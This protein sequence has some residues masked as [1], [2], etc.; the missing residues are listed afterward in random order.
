ME[1]HVLLELQLP[2]TIKLFLNPYFQPSLTLSS[3]LSNSII[4]VSERPGQSPKV[5]DFST[6]LSKTFRLNTQNWA[7][8]LSPENQ[9]LLLQ[10]SV[11]LKHLLTHSFNLNFSV[12]HDRDISIDITHLVTWASLVAQGS[13]E[14]AC[15]DRRCRFDLWVKKIPWRRKWQPTPVFLPG[16]S[17]GQTRLVGYSSWGSQNN[18]TWLSN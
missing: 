6:Y 18:Q 4:Q 12:I 15:Q 7:H 3:V 5:L 11:P 1:F 2:S 9:Y 16:K 13:Q 10:C 14:F 8:H 17:H